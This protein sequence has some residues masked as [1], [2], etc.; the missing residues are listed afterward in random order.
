MA[1]EK[2][3]EEEVAEMAR[4]NCGH[5]CHTVGLN[6]WAASCPICGCPNPKYKSEEA[7]NRE[8]RPH[9]RLD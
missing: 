9:S 8:R 7:E 4:K 5:M 1:R 6:P 3:I 2:S